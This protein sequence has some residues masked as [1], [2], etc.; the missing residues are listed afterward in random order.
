MLV[1]GDCLSY[2]IS[3]EQH[4]FRN[5]CDCIRVAIDYIHVRNNIIVSLL[6]FR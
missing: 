2:L 5:I 1:S 6:T 4:V 3:R